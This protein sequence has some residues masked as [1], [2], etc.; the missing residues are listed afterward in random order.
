MNRGRREKKEALCL[1][2]AW[3]MADSLERRRERNERAF[4][5]FFLAHI[6]RYTG[7]FEMRLWSQ[8]IDHHISL[9]FALGL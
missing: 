6:Q 3:G 5:F 9:I 2:E 1:F 7:S 4:F 8:G